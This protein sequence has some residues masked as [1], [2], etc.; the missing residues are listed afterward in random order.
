M[1]VQITYRVTSDV[2]WNEL[3]STE[4]G[5]NDLSIAK[6]THTNNVESILEDDYNK[7]VRLTFADSAALLDW[8]ADYA[9]PA[10]NYTKSGFQLNMNPTY[11]W[12]D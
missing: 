9:E 10:S 12:P 1:A 4:I 2:K 3:D 5:A 7:L 11:E 8:R 6:K